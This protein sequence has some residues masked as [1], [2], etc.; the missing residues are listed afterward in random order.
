ML[1]LL[2]EGALKVQQ[3]GNLLLAEVAEVG[4]TRL[5]HELGESSQPTLLRQCVQ[6]AVLSG[7]DLD[8][9]PHTWMLVRACVQC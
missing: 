5:L 6:R 1:L 8:S 3:Q 7:A 2:V 4:I 9:G